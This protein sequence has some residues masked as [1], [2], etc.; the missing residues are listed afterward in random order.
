MEHVFAGLLTGGV[1]GLVLG[2][3]IALFSRDGIW[4]NV[5]GALIIAGAGLGAVLGAIDWMVS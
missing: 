4:P 5:W 1:G 2:I 3:F